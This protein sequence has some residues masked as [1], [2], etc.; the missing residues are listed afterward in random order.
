M[1][2]IFKKTKDRLLRKCFINYPGKKNNWHK[3][4]AFHVKFIADN[5]VYPIEIYMENDGKSN[6]LLIYE[7]DFPNRRSSKYECIILF[8]ILLQLRCGKQPKIKF[9]PKEMFS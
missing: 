4:K 1:N 6:P 2:R 7:R 3:S 9:L 8:E 5:E